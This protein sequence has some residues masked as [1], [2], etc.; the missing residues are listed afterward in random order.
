MHGRAAL[1]SSFVVVVAAVGLRIHF[2]H[3]ESAARVSA[4]GPE[5]KHDF[6]D[7]FDHEDV[8]AREWG[9]GTLGSATYAFVPSDRHPLHA[10]SMSTLAF[11][12]WAS[13]RV[14][15]VLP[16]ISSTGR[17][18]I[19]RVTFDVRFI[20]IEPFRS[21]RPRLGVGLLPPRGDQF[22]RFRPRPSRPW[23]CD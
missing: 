21:A 9:P 8:P 20:D 13:K 12:L 17:S 7:D 14:S 16:G 22:C 3:S 10:L 1:I 6:C 11:G 18:T 5:N 23:D 19:I 15:G 2:E 4:S